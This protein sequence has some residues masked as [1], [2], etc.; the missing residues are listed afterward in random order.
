MKLEE[1][2]SV[3]SDYQ[4]LFIYDR[5]GN[6]LGNYDKRNSIDPKYAECS[7]VNI[8]ARKNI[9]DITLDVCE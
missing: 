1:L 4:D 7:V 6:D 2:F 8:T 5:D 9:F 3:L